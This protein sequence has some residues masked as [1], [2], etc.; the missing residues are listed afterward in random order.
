MVVDV[1][2]FAKYEDETE[3]MCEEIKAAVGWYNPGYRVPWVPGGWIKP[4]MRLTG[5]EWLYM[6]LMADD[7]QKALENARRVL[8]LP[9][10]HHPFE[11][12]VVVM[13][14]IVCKYTGYMFIC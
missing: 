4:F 9:G 3:Q 7:V 6:D 11:C 10:D 12:E 5:N 13:L 1:M 8:Q 14:E 2:L